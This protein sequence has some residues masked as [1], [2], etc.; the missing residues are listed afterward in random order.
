MKPSIG[1]YPQVILGE[2][3]Q[4]RFAM[5]FN[6]DLRTRFYN[7]IV[8]VEKGSFFYL[9]LY[10]SNWQG[11]RPVF[12]LPI[13]TPDIGGDNTSALM[14]DEWVSYKRLPDLELMNFLTTPNARFYIQDA[15][16]RRYYMSR[17]N[18]NM[19][20]HELECP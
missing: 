2:D 9:P 17:R 1:I 19:V 3:N 13:M 12:H 15:R 7:S 14:V 16:N 8:S 4:R 11:F 18:T 20:K 6:I 10:I 5:L